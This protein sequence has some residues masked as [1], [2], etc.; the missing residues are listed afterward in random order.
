MNLLITPKGPLF[1]CDT[2]VN[3]NPSA[4]EI[5]DMTLM[6]AEGVRRFGITP[7]VALLSH[8][9]FGSHKTDEARK[10]ADALQ[11]IHVQAPELEAEGEMQADTALSETLRQRLFPNSRLQGAANLLIM[12]NLDAANVAFNLLKM[13][14]D[15]VAIG[16]I[17]LGLD[18]PA[19]ILTGA[20][21]VRRIV[22]MTAVAAVDA[23]MAE[24]TEGIPV[25]P[26]L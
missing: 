23:Q 22:N 24:R 25:S 3:P 17:L 14:S 6:A 2:D 13:I 4:A 10:M 16:P 7:K 11:L 9:N 18:R 26:L 21:T 5:A 1:I 12:P 8:S 19:H 15:S 20:A